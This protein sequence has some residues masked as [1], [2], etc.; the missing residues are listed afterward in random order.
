MRWAWPFT[1]WCFLL[2][3]GAWAIPYE[4]VPNPRPQGRYISDD[5]R[6]L[7]DSLRDKLNRSL[8][9]LER[10]NGTQIAVVIVQDC[11]GRDVRDYAHRL[12][13]FWGVGQRGVNNGVLFLVA[14]KEHRMEVATGDGVRPFVSDANLEQMLKQEVVPHFKGGHPDQGVDQGVGWLCKRLA[15]CRYQKS[16]PISKLGQRIADPRPQGS[17]VADPDHLLKPDAVRTLHSRLFPLIA[18]QDVQ[19]V[20]VLVASTN[21]TQA[22]A[23]ELAQAWQIQGRDGIFVISK[24]PPGCSLYMTPDSLAHYQPQFIQSMQDKARKAVGNWH[25]AQAVDELVSL[26]SHP[27][28]TRQAPPSRQPVSSPAASTTPDNS[29]GLGA[30]ALGSFATLGAG[31]RYLRYR[32]RKCPNCQGPMIRLD[33]VSDDEYLTQGERDEERLGSVDYD[34]W[35][36]PACEVTQKGRYAAWLSNFKSCARCGYRTLSSTNQVLESATEYSEGRGE[37]VESCHSCSYHNRSYYTIARITVSS[38]SDS[39]SSSYDSSSSSSSS[40]SSWGGGSS[41][42]GAGASW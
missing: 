34:I 10:S 38:S 42:G 8:S 25:L 18:G 26:V 27:Q 20:A 36:C 11:S 6:L 7:K 9:N 22:L 1:L 3:L 23:Q 39:S 21:S 17:L 28:P 32:K 4:N 15:S 19:V 31:A 30:L 24:K 35:L 29:W 13:N 33:E 37:T 14:M 2:T 41:S 5:T 12:F 16:L 40:D